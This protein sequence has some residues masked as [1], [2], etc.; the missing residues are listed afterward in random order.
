[1]PNTFV[2]SSGPPRPHK[3]TYSLYTRFTH[4]CFSAVGKE[5]R[6]DQGTYEE[7][8]GNG[9]I[10]HMYG[11]EIMLQIS[12]DGTEWGLTDQCYHN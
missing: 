12:T 7:L 6:K 1:M 3:Q 11:S 9:E 4:S 2:F 5:A 10:T 8:R